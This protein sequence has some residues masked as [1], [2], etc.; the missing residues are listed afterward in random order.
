MTI[1]HHWVATC[2]KEWEYSVNFHKQDGHPKTTTP[3]L[4]EQCS[5]NIIKTVLKL[6]VSCHHGNN[7]RA[8]WTEHSLSN[9]LGLRW[10]MISSLWFLTSSFASIPRV[11]QTIPCATL[12]I[13]LNQLHIK[14]V[15]FP[16]RWTCSQRYPFPNC[17]FQH[18]SMF[19]IGSI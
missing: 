16:I 17:C 8:V 7:H 2:W 6:R 19:R 13:I 14:K 4:R 15:L 9:S 5:T 18:I 3:L 11:W 10:R 12:H 1:D